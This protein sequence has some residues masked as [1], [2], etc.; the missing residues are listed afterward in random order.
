MSNKPY[1]RC[2]G[3]YCKHHAHLEP[4]TNEPVFLICREFEPRP[5]ASTVT[6]SGL[7]A[8]CGKNYLMHSERV[9]ADGSKTRVR[10]EKT[11]PR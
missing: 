3:E 5:G 9:S 11:A 4:C 10:S 6:S 7:C 1:C 8:E 2:T